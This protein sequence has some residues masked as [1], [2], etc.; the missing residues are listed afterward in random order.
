MASAKV[1]EKRKAVLRARG[2]PEKFI[3]NIA[4]RNG[5]WVM[6]V[7]AVGLWLAVWALLMTSIFGSLF[8]T[9]T[10][11]AWLAPFIYPR[12]RDSL[13]FEVPDDLAITVG[14][15]IVGF[16]IVV[17][18]IVMVRAGR[19]PV[20]PFPAYSVF[21]E[22]LRN[23][24]GYETLDTI[25][26]QPHL[27]EMDHLI[28]DRAFLQDARPPKAKMRLT[29]LLVFT[30]LFLLFLLSR[31][32]GIFDTTSVDREAI[33]LG[34]WQGETP[35]PLKTA[36]FAYVTCYDNPGLSTR[37]NYRIVFARDTFSIW[38]WSDPVHGLNEAGV[39]DRIDQVDRQLA[40]LNVPIYR[41]PPTGIPD[42]DPSTCIAKLSRYW[43]LK[44]PETLRHLVSG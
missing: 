20:R 21:G 26:H 22:Y 13:L 12:A 19:G 7:G 44:S 5:P 18:F 29:A 34:D 10:I 15:T 16:V 42:H 28:D 1:I 9:A 35:Y 11:N 25:V 43:H 2:V 17:A 30:A 6:V 3:D 33:R 31:V 8:F 37:F 23:I 36:K 32:V 24:G 40:R 38:Q 4:R 41:A 27:S 39:I 14:L